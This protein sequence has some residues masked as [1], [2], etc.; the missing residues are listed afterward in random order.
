MS[1]RLMRL[2]FE[3][4]LGLHFFLRLRLA[5]GGGWWQLPVLLILGVYLSPRVPYLRAWLP[6]QALDYILLFTPYITGFL[7]CFTMLAIF[8][9]LL[10]LLTMLFSAIAKADFSWGKI[11]AAKR[12][13]PVTLILSAALFGYGYYEAYHPRLVHISLASKKLP[14]GVERLRIVQLSDVHLSHF[15]GYREL[16]KI[17][18]LAQSAQP[19]ILTV[20]GDLVDSDMSGR[21]AEADLLSTIKA[22]YGAFGVLG[23]HELYVGANNSIAFYKRAGLTLLR[24]EA[25]VSGG[26]VIAG[27][28][29]EAFRESGNRKSALQLLRDYKDDPRFVLFLKHRPQLA[30]GT[31]GLFDLQLSGHTHGGQIW[32]A[33]YLVGRANGVVNGLH[34]AEASRG[35]VYT[36]RGAGFWGLPMRLLAPP[37]VAVIDLVNENST[38]N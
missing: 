36:S 13:V 21:S 7:I 24:G 8:F 31:A 27:V 35:W 22:P 6:S 37:E 32:P 38:K 3:A 16:E 12:L 2:I 4:G 23:N 18:E 26:L 5:F 1:F 11:F 20:T 34:K 30:P 10:R 19:D 9:D 25:K 15:L 28:D 33:H 17:V 14:P 29:D